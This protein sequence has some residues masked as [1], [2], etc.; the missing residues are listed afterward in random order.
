MKK[1]TKQPKNKYYIYKI[2]YDGYV[3]ADFSTHYNKLQQF[4]RMYVK[5]NN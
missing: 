1:N 2:I 4:M 3:I 5:K